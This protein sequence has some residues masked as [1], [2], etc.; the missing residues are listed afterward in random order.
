M[1]YKIHSELLRKNNW[2]MELGLRDAIRSDSIV[3]LADSQVIRWIDQING[4]DSNELQG[5]IQN[6]RR[7]I[8][9]LKREDNTS[10]NTKRIQGLYF[11]L[12]NLMLIP[13]YF[14]LVIDSDKDYLRA[15]QGFIFNGMCFRRL[16]STSNGVKTGVIVFM[17]EFGRNGS[18]MRDE[19]FRR[20]ENDRDLTKE[21]IPAKL[22]SYRGLT[23]SASIPV[24]NPKGVLVVP[25]TMVK[26]KGDYILLSDNPDGVGEPTYEEVVGGDCENNAS[27][28]FGLIKPE[29]MEIWSAEL[30]QPDM[31]SGVCVR[32][33]F[34][35]GMLFP[36]DID[37][38]AGDVAH[39]YIV[40][41]IWGNDVNILDVDIIMSE[42]ML[43][44]WDSYESWDDYWRKSTANGYTFCVTKIAENKCKE[45]K[46]LNYQFINPMECSD[47]DLE[48]L[49][50]PTIDDISGV[51]GGDVAKAI[52]YL[53]G[54][55]MTESSISKIDEDWIRALMIDE[56]VLNDPYIR[57]KINTLIRRRI[58]RAKLGR[59]RVRG[60][61][62]VISFDPYLFCESAFGMTPC[63]LL[64]AGEVYSQYWLRR[65]VHEVVAMRAPMTI[66]SN[67]CKMKV[68]GTEEMQHWYRYMKNILIL[69]SWDQTAAA[70]NG[71]DCDGDIMMTTDNPVLLRNYDTITPVQCAQKKGE[72]VIVTDDD[73]VK[74]NMASFGDDIGVVTNRA[75]GMFDVRSMFDSGSDEY[76]ELSKRLAM[77]Q[78]YQQDCIN[79]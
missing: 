34:T 30:D 18:V 3:T 38:F 67:I 31:A 27:D 2:N 45:S 59:I 66:A 56:R 65:N 52:I 6:I 9:A 55:E 76:K 42:S 16:V 78:K 12:N 26:F 53:K 40:K 69:N 35:K 64:K 14:L 33:S 74:S 23:C 13:E 41:D 58:V 51:C 73:V 7:K 21:M 79:D 39:N 25:D 15:V 75:T 62:H 29:L 48:E 72:K 47:E 37:A 57:Q 10:E 61:F 44:L 68:A 70:A 49:V 20:I 60:D 4:Q 1:V 50:A 71:C 5:E 54:E 28:G 11:R 63:G 36:F 8:R 22:E 32:Q 24:S 43:K 46:E 19:V 17:A 77:C